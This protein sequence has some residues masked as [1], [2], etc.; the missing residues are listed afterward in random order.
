MFDL[1]KTGTD[2]LFILPNG[3]FLSPKSKDEISDQQVQEWERLM[4]LSMDSLQ[5]MLQEVLRKKLVPDEFM[6]IFKVSLMLV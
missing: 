3:P 2:C 4:S 1:I 5:Q 6:N